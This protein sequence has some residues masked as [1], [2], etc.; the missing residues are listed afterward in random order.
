MEA[1]L[2]AI[3][4][5]IDGVL[6]NVNSDGLDTAMAE[7]V[8][9]R[10]VFVEGEGRSG[11]MARGFAM[12]LMHLGYTVFVV[13]ETITPALSEADVFI[14]VSG[15]GTGPHVLVDAAKAKERGCRVIAFTSKNDSTLAG[16]ADV[17]AVIP[18]T[19]RG[20]AG[21]ERGSMQLLSSLF[22]QSLHIVLDA[23]CLKISRR[24]AVN[25]QTATGTHW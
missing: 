24:D 7:I 9:G 1:T 15:S 10:R 17:V 13:G 25:N 11:L 16:L 21:A 12:R 4:K 6:E 19:V 3:I 14:G 2:Q 20:D 8:P 22:D 23:L 5:E 18:G